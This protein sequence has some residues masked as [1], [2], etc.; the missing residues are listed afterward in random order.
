MTRKY[1]LKV[2]QLGIPSGTEFIKNN[3]YSQYECDCLWDGKASIPSRYVEENP[4]LFEPVI[5]RW[6]P[7][8]HE[9]YWYIKNTFQGVGWTGF[10]SW[11][12]LARARTGNCFKTDDQAKEALRRTQAVLIA[13]HQELAEEDYGTETT[14][15]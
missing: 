11:P 9:I 7:E 10:H 5:E 15:N 8:D 6:K 12:D 13:Y 14:D 3:K 2:S 4:D 1:R